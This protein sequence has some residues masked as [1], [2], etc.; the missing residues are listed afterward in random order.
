MTNARYFDGRT[1]IAHDAQVDIG[2]ETLTIEAAG[3]RHIWRYPEL[4]RA[5][6]GNGRVILKR[7]SDSGERISL[8]MDAAP[9]LRTVAPALFKSRAQGVE[10]PAV[11][12]GV[13]AAA[14][15]IAALFLVG[16]P[17]AADPI[18]RYMPAQ[19]R[20]QIG[21]V[22]WAQVDNFSQYC[23]DSDEAEAILNG[24]A[25]RMMEASDVAQRD[26]IWITLVDAPIP[27]AFAL[28][29]NSIIVTDELIAMAEHPDEVVAVIA[30]E[31]AHIERNHVMQGIVRQIGAGI[32]FDV[33]FGGA[34]AGQAI[35][36][37]SMNL[38]GLRYTRDD[39]TEA[40]T[41]G[42]AFLDAAGINP[43]PI[44]A[45]FE[46]LSEM[47][48]ERE[49]GEFPAILSSHPAN[50]ERAAA[51]RARARPDLPPSLDERQWAIVRQACGGGDMTNAGQE[52]PATEAE[53]AAETPPTP[54]N[55]APTPSAPAPD[56]ATPETPPAR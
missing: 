36:L 14:W 13:A 53:P 34:G 41:R 42:F 38:A 8:D 32:F 44:A 54:V 17:F 37:S 11:V 15:S 4:R 50:S 55:P 56:R 5:D 9:A 39:E 28:P 33:M 30:H 22:A 31:I 1:A 46:R 16:V 40:D 52:A 27:N 19:Y 43:G 24:V 25:Y 2:A 23:D 12:G 26:Q 20:E 10:S 51:A 18:A 49:R 7:K 29:D 21:D 48:Q 6:D 3:D 45:L 47:M 35:A